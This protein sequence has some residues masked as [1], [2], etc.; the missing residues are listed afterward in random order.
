MDL[1]S[2]F[3]A[4]GLLS[5]SGEVCGGSETYSEHVRLKPYGD[6]RAWWGFLWNIPFEVKGERKPTG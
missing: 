2:P 4:S 1:A 6:A 5:I 3:K